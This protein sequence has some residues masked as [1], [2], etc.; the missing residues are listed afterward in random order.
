MVGGGGGS[1]VCEAILHILGEYVFT[2]QQGQQTVLQSAVC[3]AH[4][5]YTFPSTSS[6]GGSR[7]FQTGVPTPEFEAKTYYLARFLP[8][9]A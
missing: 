8:K 2:E 7:I 4:W 3:D 6:S 1:Q 5:Q 9:T